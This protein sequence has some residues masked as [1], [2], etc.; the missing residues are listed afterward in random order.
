MKEYHLCVI[1]KN[2]CPAEYGD[3]IYKGLCKG[4][5]YN[6]GFEMYNGQ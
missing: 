6:K 2:N 5:D 3:I 4:C 1:D